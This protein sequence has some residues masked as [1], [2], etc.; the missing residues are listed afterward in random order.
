M[1]TTSHLHNYNYIKT[2]KLLHVLNLTGSSSGHTSNSF[3]QNTSN[4]L[5]Y[6]I[7]QYINK[8]HYLN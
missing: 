2:V 7:I 1:L 8:I 4:Y 5:Y 6:V 3:V